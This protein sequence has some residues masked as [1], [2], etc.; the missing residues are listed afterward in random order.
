MQRSVSFDFEKVSMAMHDLWLV[1]L[2][3]AIL[4]HGYSDDSNMIPGS[5][6]VFA[7]HDDCGNHATYQYHLSVREM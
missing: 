7:N 5:E 2:P 4:I 6:G 1:N 3:A